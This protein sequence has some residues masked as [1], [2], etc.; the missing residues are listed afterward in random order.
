[1]AKQN[2]YLFYSS[3]Y[4]SVI[5][6]LRLGSDEE[7]VRTAAR[8]SKTTNEEIRV[9]REVAIVDERPSMSALLESE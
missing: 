6:R 8:I 1:M 3:F 9:Y 7:A 5:D 4:N 2:N